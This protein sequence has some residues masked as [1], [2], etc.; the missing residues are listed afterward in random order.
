METNQ[1][2]EDRIKGALYGMFIADALA[3]PVHWYYDREALIRDYGWVTGYLAPKNPHPD[4]ILWRSSYSPR[5][6]MSLTRNKSPNTP[7][8]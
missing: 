5:N 4:S 7:A 6:Q 8:N 2:N 1:L 3:M